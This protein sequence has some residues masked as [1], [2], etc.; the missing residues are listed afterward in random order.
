MGHIEYH[1]LKL[2]VS[3]Y[4]AY[5]FNMEQNIPLITYM[6]TVQSN[7]RHFFI[8]I[9]NQPIYIYSDASVNML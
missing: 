9:D 7:A 8:D 2:Q 1:L 5:I 4:I 6:R 3:L